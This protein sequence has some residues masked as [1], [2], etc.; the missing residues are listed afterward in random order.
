MASGQTAMERA[1][2]ELFSHI[3]RCGVVKASAD[4]QRQW[5]DETVE[6]LGE[7]YSELSDADLKEL[8]QVGVRFCQPAI[9]NT[10]RAP[11]GVGLNLGRFTP[12]APEAT[13]APA[14][15]D[16]GGATAVATEDSES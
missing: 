9:R 7:R 10:D 16:E 6:Y 8:F 14:L 13:A 5:L 2:D 15:Q 4:D 12:R 1:R 3:N 11:V